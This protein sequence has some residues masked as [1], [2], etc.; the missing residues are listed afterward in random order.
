MVAWFP[1]AI[2]DLWRCH[3]WPRWQV[4]ANPK[5]QPEEEF[6]PH[7]HNPNN[8]RPKL[9]SS[10]LIDWW[11]VVLWTP[12]YCCIRVTP[13]SVNISPVYWHHC[14]DVWPREGGVSFGLQWEILVHGQVQ[15][16]LRVVI[17]RIRAGVTKPIDQFHT[18]HNVHVPCPTMHHSEQKCAQFSAEWCIE[19]YG[20]GA[21]A[22]FVN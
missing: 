7:P 12:C 21:F 20:N 15:T 18:S 2:L 17:R 13:I 19:G 9:L 8:P 5:W 1:I 22:G 11:D 16:V 4:T 3:F 6:H 14:I 10:D